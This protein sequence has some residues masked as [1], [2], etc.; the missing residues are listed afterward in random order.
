MTPEDSLVE[1]E[2]QQ[3]M[4][5]RAEA[6]FLRQTS[7]WRDWPLP[8]LAASKRRQDARIIVVIPARNEERTVGG[9]VSAV[10]DVLMTGVPL[11]DEVVVM[12]SDSTDAT[13]EIAA[14]AGATVYGCRDIGPGLASYPGKGEA[15]WKSAAA[16][17]C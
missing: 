1:A 16:G 14:R 5:E 13:A 11:M 7:T 4:N 3:P 9:V 2:R 6:W 15:L 8:Q 10:R 12:D 17:H